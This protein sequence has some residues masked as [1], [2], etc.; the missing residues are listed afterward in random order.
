MWFRRRSGSAG[1][2]R[3]LERRGR[4]TQGSLEQRKKPSLCGGQTA[5][6]TWAGTAHFPWVQEM[7]LARGTM[8]ICTLVLALILTRTAM[9]MERAYR[10]SE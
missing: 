8:V 2:G 10:R 5:S 9:M 6:G 7:S 3:V 4:E 1:R